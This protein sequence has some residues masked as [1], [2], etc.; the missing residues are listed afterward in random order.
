MERYKALKALRRKGLCV[1]EKRKKQ[2]I[3]KL[4]P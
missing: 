4:S 2:N 1:T 3:Q